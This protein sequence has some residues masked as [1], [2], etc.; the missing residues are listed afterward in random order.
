MVTALF[1]PPDAVERTL[2]TTPTTTRTDSDNA[3]AA[4]A[5]GVVSGVIALVI[6]IAVFVIAIVTWKHRHG[7]F[8]IQHTEKSVKK[9]NRVAY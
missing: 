6:A 2:Y 4:I 9:S 1:P 5:G 8:S 3:T 7:N